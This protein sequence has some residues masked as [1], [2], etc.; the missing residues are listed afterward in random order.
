MRGRRGGGYNTT[1]AC[2]GQLLASQH[3]LPQLRHGRISE[4]LATSSVF[5][6]QLRVQVGSITLATLMGT[7]GGNLGM[8]T[9]ISVMTIMEVKLLCPR[10]LSSCPPASPY[11]QSFFLYSSTL[12]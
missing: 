6:A 9:G 7:I 1:T 3:R 12:L 4:G 2:Q 10:L 5:P 8:F 11:T